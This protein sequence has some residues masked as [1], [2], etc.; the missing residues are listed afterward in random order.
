MSHLLFPPHQIGLLAGSM[1]SPPP[2]GLLV[3]LGGPALRL[4]PGLLGAA[5][6][7][8][9]VSVVAVATQLDLPVAARA[10]EETIAGL[11]H[12]SAQKRGLDAERRSRH[13]RPRAIAV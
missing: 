3:A 7:A 13:A 4:Q 11:I 10:V 9:L 8:V 12:R 6:N 5:I 1:V 2:L